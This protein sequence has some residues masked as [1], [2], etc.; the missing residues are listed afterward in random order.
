[1]K[2]KN[3][4]EW[5]H[6][7]LE[8]AEII[9]IRYSIKGMPV[10]RRW[11]CSIIREMQRYLEDLLE[12]DGHEPVLFPVLIPEDSLGKETEHIAGFEEQVFWVTHAGKTPLERKMALRPTSETSMYGLFSLWIRT[13]TDLPLKVHQSVCVYRYETKHT[14]PLIRGR[15]FLW[16]EGHAAFATKEDAEENIAAIKEIYGMLISDLLC[17]P[18]QINQRPDWDK[19][20]GAVYTLAFETLMPDGRT[21]QVAT[22]HNLGQNFS[23]PFNITYEDDEGKRHHCYQTSYGPGFGRLLAA[24]IGIHGDDKG[25]VLPPKIAPVQVVIIPIVFKESE[26]DQIMDFAKKIRDDIDSE[27]IK[28]ELDDTEQRPGAKYYAW[29]MKGVPVRLEIGP[30]ELGKKSVVVVRRDNGE[31]EVVAINE[32]DIRSVFKKIEDNMRETA[33]KRFDERLLKATDL[34]ALK[35]KI[36]KGIVTCGWCEGGECTKQIDAL[37]TILTIEG[38]EH[39]CVVCGKKG[40]QIT[41]AKS[42]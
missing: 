19:F 2:E 9:D 3:F 25:L 38:K 17:L 21:L 30:R 29:E 24:I 14:R 32:L 36:G 15:E 1:M 7:I 42:Y 16:N 34:S 10:Y 11:G 41:V 20:P 22:A 40:R 35:K 23:K 27:G 39:K 37:G 12:K 33:R 18:Y 8:D 6:K 4:S 13:H 5:Y 31:K 26:K 28:V